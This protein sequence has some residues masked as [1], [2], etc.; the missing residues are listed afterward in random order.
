MQI[1]SAS[2]SPAQPYDVSVRRAHRANLLLRIRPPP[3]NQPPGWIAQG[4]SVQEWDGSAM[5]IPA[6]VAAW[7]SAPILPHPEGVKF[8]SP[9][10]VAWED[11]PNRYL[12][13]FD[14]FVNIASLHRHGSLQHCYTKQKSA[15]FSSMS[16]PEMGLKVFRE[17]GSHRCRRGDRLPRAASR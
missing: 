16:H 10:T 17:Q 12:M 8:S 6:P 4:R 1:N 9:E 3:P 5:V 13:T 2:F 14:D 7:V 11:C 15:A